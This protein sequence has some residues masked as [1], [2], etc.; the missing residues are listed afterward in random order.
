M[1]MTQ[2]LIL[3]GGGIG[4]GKSAVRDELAAR[5]VSVIDADAVGHAVLSSH[6]G[7]IA[8]V[9]DLWPD[10]VVE[11]VVNRRALGRIVFSDPTAL[12]ELEA[13]THPEIRAALH[14]R[15]DALRDQDAEGAIAVE[16][17]LDGRLFGVGWTSIIVDAP[18]DVRRARL[19]ERGLDPSEIDD[20]M[21]A[22][23]TRQEWLARA[24]IVVDNGGD[25]DSLAA[26]VDAV[27]RWIVDEA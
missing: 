9:A 11:G 16:Y 7:A 20:R 4:S 3:I 24:D 19:A 25:R 6:T 17:P 27:V 13:I 15:V 1:S 26:E 12:A 5:G 8:K 22:Q 10:V 2:R 23:P 18:D 14:E 21:A